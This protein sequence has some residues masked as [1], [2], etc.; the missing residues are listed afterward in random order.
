MITAASLHEHK[1]F[2]LRLL[3]LRFRRTDATSPAAPPGPP[4]QAGKMETMRMKESMEPLGM[5]PITFGRQ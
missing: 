4:F 1:G 3:W 2:L 5:A